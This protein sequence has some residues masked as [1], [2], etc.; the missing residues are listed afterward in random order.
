MTSVDAVEAARS[1]FEGF[2][3]HWLIASRAIERLQADE[4]VSG[5]YLSGS[6]AKGEP[7]RWSDIDL[8]VVVADGAVDEVVAS[9]ARLIREVGDVTTLFPAT[10]LGDPDQFYRARDPIHVDF[11]YRSPGA[12]SPRSQDSDVI[13]LLDRTGELECW[14]DACRRQPAAMRPTIERLQYLE[15]RFWDWC[16]YAHAKIE[17]GEL[18]EARDAIEYVRSQVLVPLAHRDGQLFEGNRRLEDKLPLDV[19]DLLAATVPADHSADAYSQTLEQM[20]SAYSRL[21]DALPAEDRAG[22][23]QVDRAYFA[24]VVRKRPGRQQA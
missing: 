15:D 3:E 24:E 14:R 20:M 18:W 10:H 13:I 12:L 23:R 19:Q 5:L 11:Q 2:P 17:R 1:A 6:F 8:Y 16:W 9:H 7:D 21:V 4:R 22:V